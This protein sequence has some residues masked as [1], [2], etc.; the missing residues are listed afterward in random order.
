MNR[1]SVTKGVQIGYNRRGLKAMT[2]LKMN[3]YY[4]Y[5]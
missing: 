4:Y 3:Y 2:T 1:M 5:D